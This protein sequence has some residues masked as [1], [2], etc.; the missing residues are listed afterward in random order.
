[1][2]LEHGKPLVFG[3]DR[4]RGIR[5]VG[6]RPE[7]VE[8]GGATGI[9]EDDL[10]HH[11]QTNRALALILATLHATDASEDDGA[12]GFPEPLGVLYRQERETYEAQVQQQV[13]DAIAKRGRGDL[14][15]LFRSGDTYE[16]VGDR[17][18]AHALHA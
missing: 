2:Y 11:D 15:K 17:E 8:L 3:R 4:D 5:M 6:L 18:P 1:M 12:L 14:D 10:I 13:D 9:V 16:I 7:V